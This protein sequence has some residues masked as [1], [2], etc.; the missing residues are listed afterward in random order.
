MT[1]LR[2][3]VGGSSPPKSASRSFQ[4]TGM[5]V[6]GLVPWRTKPI[7]CPGSASDMAARKI[8]KLT[9]WMPLMRLLPARK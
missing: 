5:R 3:G 2:A 9:R 8:S 6:S 1:G 4:A 7:C